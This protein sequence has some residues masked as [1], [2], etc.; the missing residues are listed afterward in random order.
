MVAL[1]P[2]EKEAFRFRGGAPSVQARLE[3][4]SAVRAVPQEANNWSRSQ[5]EESA[6]TSVL[7]S[8]TYRRCPARQTEVWGLRFIHR[9]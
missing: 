2:L 4:L 7:A 5:R 9:R 3:A 6:S 1:T 8:R